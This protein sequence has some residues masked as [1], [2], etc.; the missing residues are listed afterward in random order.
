M[1]DR[2]SLRELKCFG[3]GFFML[4]LCTAPLWAATSYPWSTR[5]AAVGGAL[6]ACGALAI[7]RP[8]LRLGG[9]I[10]GIINLAFLEA[11]MEAGIAKFMRFDE[12]L[13][14]LRDQKEMLKDEE[15]LRTGAMLV[16]IGTILNGFSGFL[17]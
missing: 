5:V 10:S 7:F 3:W 6:A 2:P 16:A 4:V 12:D 17:S 13:A 1:S 15:A 8:L 11:Y 14:R 9:P